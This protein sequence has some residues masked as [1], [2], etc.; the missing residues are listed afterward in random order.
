MKNITIAIIIILL[1][2]GGIFAYTKSNEQ[3]LPINPTPIQNTNGTTYSAEEV[4]LH[5]QA[6]NCWF[7]IEGKIYDVT[8]YVASDIHPGGTE[9]LVYNCGKDATAMFATKGDKD[10]PHSDKAVGYLSNFYIGDL[11]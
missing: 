4:S 3:K 9:A 5:N 10:E 1:I 11:K 2:A 6:G 8:K 7:I